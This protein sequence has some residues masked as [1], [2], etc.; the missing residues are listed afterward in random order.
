MSFGR[1]ASLLA[2]LFFANLIGTTMRHFFSLFFALTCL[3]ANMEA[4]TKSVT[5]VSEFNSGKTSLKVGHIAFPPFYLE[6]ESGLDADVIKA[7]A[8]RAGIKK[9]EFV[10]FPSLPDLVKS[11][12]EGK[13]DVIANGIAE[14][15]HRSDHFLLSEPY[16]FKGGLGL[17]SH[18][19]LP[20]KTSEDLKNRRIGVLTGSYPQKEWLPE[21]GVPSR[22]IHAFDSINA[23]VEAVKKREIDVAVSNYTVFR[24]YAFHSNDTLDATLVVHM[25]IVLLFKKGNVA[26]QQT[27]NEAL[28]SLWKD[29]SLY[30]IKARYLKPIGI[31][32]AHMH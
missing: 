12:N 32:P 22:I 15:P 21:L 16:Y 24:Y 10:L 8:E 26:L 6:N 7:V 2:V 3:F 17:L 13:I 30:K 31:E 20:V 1:A 27:I 11:L 28:E 18:S 14:T 4:Q 9:V 5:D 29:D 19:S 25:P 23:L